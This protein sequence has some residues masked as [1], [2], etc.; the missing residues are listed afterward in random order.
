MCRDAGLD[1]RGDMYRKPRASRGDRYVS[2]E[3]RPVRAFANIAAAAAL[4]G[5]AAGGMM[6]ARGRRGGEEAVAEPGCGAA[7]LACRSREIRPAREDEGLIN[8]MSWE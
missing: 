6:M 5:R 2:P 7:G 4:P 8:V 1:S 3:A